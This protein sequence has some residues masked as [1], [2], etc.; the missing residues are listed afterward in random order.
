MI[1]KKIVPEIVQKNGI[2]L[3]KYVILNSLKYP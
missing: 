1:L 3:S 2:L